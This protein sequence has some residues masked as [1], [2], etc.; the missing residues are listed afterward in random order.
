MLIPDFH[1]RTLWS[2]HEVHA[3]SSMLAYAVPWIWVKGIYR[4][5]LEAIWP[6]EVAVG[7]KGLVDI[8]NIETTELAYQTKEY[9]LSMLVVVIWFTIGL[10][11]LLVRIVRYLMKRHALRVLTIKCGDERHRI[12]QHYYQ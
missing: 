2:K 11:L 10:A 1:L 5:L 4:Y 12:S 3:F 8:A 9:Q 6:G 7:A